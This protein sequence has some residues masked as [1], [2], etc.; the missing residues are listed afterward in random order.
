MKRLEIM[1]G[2]LGGLSRLDSRIPS[3][4]WALCCF[5]F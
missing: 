2:A 4:R 3:Y 1:S 5:F